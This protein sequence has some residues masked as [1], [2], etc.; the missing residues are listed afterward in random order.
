MR[1]QLFFL[2]LSASVMMASAQ[3]KSAVEFFDTT[4]VDPVSKFGWS[5]SKATSGSKTMSP[6]TL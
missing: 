3:P 2:A 1:K 5:G 6:Y 4:G